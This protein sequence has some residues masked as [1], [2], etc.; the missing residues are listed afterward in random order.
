MKKVF[1]MV[2]RV[3]QETR[4]GAHKDFDEIVEQSY[5]GKMY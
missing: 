3:A 5:Q 4:S 2:G 1:V